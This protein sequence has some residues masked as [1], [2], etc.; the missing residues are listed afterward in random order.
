VRLGE[1]FTYAS[2]PYRSTTSHHLYTVR[3][4]DEEVA[5]TGNQAENRGL[6]TRKEGLE[7]EHNP[8]TPEELADQDTGRLEQL[9]TE[10]RG[11]AK[12][13][14]KLDEDKKKLFF[15]I[16]ANMFEVSL[17]KVKEHVTV[18]VWHELELSSQDP[19][20]LWNAIKATHTIVKPDNDQLT[21]FAAEAA[22]S[23]IK[24]RLNELPISYFNRINQAIEIVKSRDVDVETD[25]NYTESARVLRMVKG[26][27]PVRFGELQLTLDQNEKMGLDTMP[28]TM[29]AALE[30]INE[31]KV[32]APSSMQKPGGPFKAVFAAS[33]LTKGP[34]KRKSDKKRSGKPGQPSEVPTK[35]SVFWWEML[36]M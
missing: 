11:N 9:K 15:T 36:Q 14:V 18:P 23:N 7:K 31:F 6:C 21:L 33:V 20:V 3:K 19:L 13:G 10:N 2:E 25:R 16:W 30:L 24:M 17:Q 1:Y 26:L 35:R 27:D 28:K 5:A 12:K 34:S 4:L 8:K 32:K 29:L 22:Y